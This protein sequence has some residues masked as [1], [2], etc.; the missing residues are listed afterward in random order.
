MDSIEYPTKSIRPPAKINPE[1]FT[2]NFDVFD[3]REMQAARDLLAQE[4]SALMANQ[5]MA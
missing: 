3:A 4:T 2:Q 5:G 1:V